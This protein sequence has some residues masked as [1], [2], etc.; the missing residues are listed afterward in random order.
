MHSRGQQSRHHSD[1][2]SRV[3]STHGSI[4]APDQA[5]ARKVQAHAQ[6]STESCFYSF[7]DYAD[8]SDYLNA[9]YYPNFKEEV[10]PSYLHDDPEEEAF[11][12]ITTY[13]N[14]GSAN[15]TEVA[16]FEELTPTLDGI[17]SHDHKGTLV[18]LRGHQPAKVLNTVGAHYNVD[19]EFYRR[20]LDFRESSGRNE[21]FSDVTLPS[22]GSHMIQLWTTTLGT[23]STHPESSFRED[24]ENLDDLRSFSSGMMRS[25]ID[26]IS[27][28]R[29]QSI[30]Y[31][32]SIVRDFALHDRSTF[33]IEQAMSI[34]VSG[35]ADR[36]LC[37]V[38]LDYGRNLGHSEGP[39]L[40]D[41]LR[42][43]PMLV[44]YWPTLQQRPGL[45]LDTKTIQKLRKEKSTKPASNEIAQTARLLHE[46][47]GCLLDNEV[48]A[49]DPFYA[50]TDIFRFAASS[51]A[52]FLEMMQSLLHKE[53]DP[54]KHRR[55]SG[56]GSG[57]I[58][59]TLV[60]WN[61]VY[62][63]QLT[64][65]HLQR[66]AKTVEFLEARGQDDMTN[67]T[68]WPRPSSESARN[69]ANKAARLLLA[70]YRHLVRRATV[71]R[72]DFVS[73]MTILM[74]AAAI[75]ESQKAIAQAEGVAKLTTLAFF[76]VP[77]SFTTSVFGMNFR[78]LS[79]GNH[80]SLWVWSLTAAG[81]LILT[82]LALQ[83]FALR[84]KLRRQM[85][86][87]APLRSGMLSTK[88]GREAS[89]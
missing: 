49:Q 76:F 53:M 18:F 46:E 4:A 26:K 9:P 58:D 50:L 65:R 68:L 13:S 81:T 14:D 56:S 3:K 36:W 66:L 15:R 22:S 85:E 67:G 57:S 24:H 25:Y 11:V 37:L 40:P 7:L 87:A 88:L 23:R 52:Q 32:D 70:D 39:W 12:V 84:H 27:V 43:T 77:L 78:E 42:C 6:L 51:E 89:V 54:M 61:L 31:G 82:Y 72:E 74:N 1:T 35:S 28:A 86:D 71:L 48:M 73:S 20:H 80:L 44:R 19:P 55:G 62:N 79:D 59:K 29:A 83:W 17:S 69:T 8:L 60:M 5:Y 47:Y 16:T 75:D 38:W 30:S 10:P 64:E 41:A 34:Y 33:S 2:S 45:I 21:C 63:K